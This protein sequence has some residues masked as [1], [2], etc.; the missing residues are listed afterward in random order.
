MQDHRPRVPMGTSPGGDLPSRSRSQVTPR[1]VV[2]VVL[3]AVAVL[4]ALYLLYTLQQIVRWLVIAVF[5]A[6]AL[7]PLVNWLQRRHVPRGLAIGLVYLALL[8][9]VAALGALV[10]PPVVAQ[11][12]GLVT[13]LV[14][15]VR[16]PGGV[17]AEVEKLARQYGLADYVDAL[18][19]QIRALPSQL[20]AATGPLIQVTKGV[21]GSVTALL[22]ILLLSFFL[23]LDGERFVEAGLGLV[24]PPQRPR[25][26][27]LLA[28][29]AAAVHGY[30]SG[31]LAISLIAGVG[32][33]LVM[34]L[35][36]VPYAVA[37]ALLV[38]L[39]DLIPL[40]GATLGAAIVVIVGFFVSPL[41]AIILLVYF[42]IY[43]QVENNVLQ[44]LVY[45][46]SVKLHPLVIFVAVLVGGAL[47][48]IL[49]ALIAIPIAEIIRIG[50]AEWLASRWDETSAAGVPP[51]GAKDP[52]ARAPG[53]G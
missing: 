13:T 2:V 48:G 49:G 29:A 22:S 3:T 6:A 18:R 46:R 24:A 17:T 34:A 30:I 10:L 37:L 47:L 51:T 1:T 15:T 42:I 32:A 8:L 20:S 4:A 5:L 16:Q 28:Q 40:V 27:R 23:L 39:L 14:D 19:T 12:R 43:Q 35:L 50:A 52:T 25:L 7:N 36:R 9:L 53:K 11:V 26:R 45:G 41:T 21:I 33:C 44:P 31:N 38:A